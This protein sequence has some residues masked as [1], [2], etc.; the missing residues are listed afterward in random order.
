VQR[1]Q[2]ANYRVAK[3]KVLSRLKI[4]KMGLNLKARRKEK[5]RVEHVQ[6]TGIPILSSIDRKLLLN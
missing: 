5:E 4:E 1:C 3:K 2:V 6:G